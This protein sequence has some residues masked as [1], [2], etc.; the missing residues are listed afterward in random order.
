[1][2]TFYMVEMHYPLDD[3]Q[4]KFSKFYHKHI[5][6]LLTIDGFFSAQRYQCTHETESPF[7]AVYRLK[8]PDVMRSKNYTSKAG[9][10][11]VDPAFKA[12]MTNWHRNLVQSDVQTMDVPEDGWLIL[13]DRHLKKCRLLPVDFT[14][15]EVIG[16]DM[17]IVERG[18]LIGD[19]GDPISID[20]QEGWNVRSFRPIHSPR[21]PQ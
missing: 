18:I 5:N 11:S 15:L 12:K 20:P 3:D 8:I 21:Y 19:K 10:D 1:M 6:M 14:S 16:L 13:I 9:R 4:T 2:N 17:T 7:L